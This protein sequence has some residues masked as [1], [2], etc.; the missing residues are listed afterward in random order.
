MK[1]GD[2]LNTAF[3]GLTHALKSDVRFTVDERAALTAIDVILD[4]DGDTTQPQDMLVAQCLK[5]LFSSG[6]FYT[7]W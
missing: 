6:E 1:D 7:A 2:T 5:K 4:A 3:K